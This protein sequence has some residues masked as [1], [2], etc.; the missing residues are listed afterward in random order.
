MNLEQKVILGVTVEGGSTVPVQ[1]DT[2]DTNCASSDSLS[3]DL[4]EVW[5]YGCPQSPLCDSESVRSSAHANTLDA[6]SATSSTFSSEESFEYHEHNIWNPMLAS[7]CHFEIGV[8]M[9]A[10]LYGVDMGK[11]CSCV[12]F[13]VGYI[14]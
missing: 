3:P 7:L 1:E 13:L 6:R 2:E 4:E 9:E 10:L 5:Q 11:N 8:G 14:V 12:P